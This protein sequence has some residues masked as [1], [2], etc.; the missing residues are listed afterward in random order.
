MP[1]DTVKINKF[2]ERSEYFGEQGLNAE[3]DSLKTESEILFEKRNLLSQWVNEYQPVEN[4][5]S[6]NAEYTILWFWTP[7]CSH[8]KKATPIFH[9]AYVEKGLKEKNIEV[10]SIF[11]NE[12]IE[13]WA[14]FLKYQKRWMEFIKKH[15]L[16]GWTNAWNPFDP[17]RTN[18]NIQSSPVLYVLDKDKKILAKRI[19]FEQALEVIEIEL[20]RIEDAEK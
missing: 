19:G 3:K 6:N 15:E 10:I 7:E 17:F 9:D 2:I 16:S 20:K 5:Y 18:F 11:L 1:Y 13:D 12:P 4:L 8:C 14:K